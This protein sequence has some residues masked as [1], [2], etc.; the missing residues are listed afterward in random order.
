MERFQWEVLLHAGPTFEGYHSFVYTELGV[1]VVG[2]L[3]S[4]SEQR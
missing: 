3:E 4:V 1:G 2:G